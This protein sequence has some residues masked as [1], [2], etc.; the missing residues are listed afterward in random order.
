M[1]HKKSSSKPSCRLGTGALKDQKIKKKLRE[2]MDEKLEHWDAE[3]DDLE[4][5]WFDL[6]KK[7]FLTASSVLEKQG[8]KHQDWFEEHN[9][10]LLK[11]IEEKDKARQATMH[12]NTRSN[13]KA[14][15]RAQSSVQ[16][17]TVEMKI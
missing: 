2:E 4:Q 5:K 11:L 7:V 15:T 14:Y 10:H 8:Q 1:Q 16:R 13:R 17:C 3:C 12:C 6:R 9:E